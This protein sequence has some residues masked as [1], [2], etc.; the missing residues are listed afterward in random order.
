M[1]TQQQT[2]TVTRK[3]PTPGELG[4][5]VII[6]LV[7]FAATLVVALHAVGWVAWVAWFLVGMEALTVGKVLMGVG[8][9]GEKRRPVR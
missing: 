3:I 4:T 7:V 1:S 8:V 6:A 5:T 2:Y 9:I